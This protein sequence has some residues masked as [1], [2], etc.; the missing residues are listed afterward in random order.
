MSVYHLSLILTADAGVVATTAIIP[1]S[2]IDNMIRVDILVDYFFQS[3]PPHPL[4]KKGELPL[5]VLPRG[6]HIAIF[7]ALIYFLN[8]VQNFDQF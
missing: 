6:T 3:T 4:G 5:L 2:I 1:I 7:P 8:L